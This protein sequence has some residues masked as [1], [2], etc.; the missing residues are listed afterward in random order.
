[1]KKIAIIHNSLF[2]IQMYS[3]SRGF[4]EILRFACALR[5]FQPAGLARF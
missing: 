2:I 1:M 5:V 3:M 4:Y